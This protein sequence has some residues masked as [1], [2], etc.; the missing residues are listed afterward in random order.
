MNVGDRVQFVAE[1]DSPPQQGTV[2][3]RYGTW[4][5]VMLDDGTRVEQ[6]LAA[7]SHFQSPRGHYC[8]LSNERSFAAVR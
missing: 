5:D 6:V 1:R 2:A 4:V 8:V 7:M 3:A